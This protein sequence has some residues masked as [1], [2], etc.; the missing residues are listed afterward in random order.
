MVER[1]I[2]IYPFLKSVH[3]LAFLLPSTLR[4]LQRAPALLSEPV[5]GCEHAGGLHRAPEALEFPALLEPQQVTTPMQVIHFHPLSVQL[6][7][8]LSICLSSDPPLMVDSGA[9]QQKSLACE[10]TVGEN[11]LTKIRSRP[12]ICSQISW[13]SPSVSC[14]PSVSVS[15]SLPDLVEIFSLLESAIFAQKICLR[16]FPKYLNIPQQHILL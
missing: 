12:T 9:V 5:C 6:A 13:F 11:M 15:F 7:Q 2:P 3:P 16:P 4:A 14:Y 8:H 10:F 1:I